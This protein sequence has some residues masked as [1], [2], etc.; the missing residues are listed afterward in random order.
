MKFWLWFYADR[1]FGD[2]VMVKMLLEQLPEHE[3]YLQV[4]REKRFLLRS[5]LSTYQNLHISDPH[6]IYVQRK[7]GFY[8]VINIGGSIFQMHTHPHG[9]GVI[10]RSL[11]NLVSKLSGLKVFVIGSN[12]GP[13]RY[14]YDIILPWILKVPDVLTVRDYYSFELARNVRGINETAFFPDM[15][16]GYDAL[17]PSKKT[18]NCLGISVYDSRNPLYNYYFCRFIAKLS[19]MY[20]ENTGDEVRLFAFETGTHRND[21]S[22]AYSILHMVQNSRMIRIIPYIG[23]VFEFAKEFSKCNTIIPVRFHSL[24]LALKFKRK[25]LPISYSIKSLNLLHDLGYSGPIVHY[26]NISNVDPNAIITKIIDNELSTIKIPKSY[27]DRA[28]GHIQMLK[29]YLGV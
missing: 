17:K 14:P 18:Q 25:F 15:V 16:F 13:I 1:N 9:L 28:K 10:R 5:L 23:D 21:L 27:L 22:C 4:E 12:I 2:D 8:G 29:H 11:K 26:N 6:K 24:V 20:V 19:D 3:F 7:R